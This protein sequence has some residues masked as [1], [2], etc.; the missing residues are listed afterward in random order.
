LPIAAVVHPE[1]INDIGDVK[2]KL[3]MRRGRSARPIRRREHSNLRSFV[4][5]LGSY[6]DERD[7]LENTFSGY[8]VNKKLL[9]FGEPGLGITQPRF[10]LSTTDQLKLQL[11][12]TIWI[13]DRIGEEPLILRRVSVEA[14]RV[15]PVTQFPWVVRVRNDPSGPDEG[16]YYTH[17]ATGNAQF[18]WL[19]ETPP[20]IVGPSRCPGNNAGGLGAHA[21]V[22]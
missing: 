11:R 18:G 8:G 2:P 6:G 1:A 9:F 20:H 3:H 12:R 15:K 22:T 16:L 5:V 14:E 10:K 17:Y 4:F 7:R 21:D 19:T 13:G